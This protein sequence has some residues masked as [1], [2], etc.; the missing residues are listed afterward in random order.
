M[1]RHTRKRNGGP[2]GLT[3]IWK[4][5]RH[6]CCRFGWFPLLVAPLVTA[7]CLLDLYSSFDCEFIR[8]NV[9]FMP[10]ND[11]W[12][13]STASLGLFQFHAMDEAN[14]WDDLTVKGCN[15]YSGG[16]ESQFIEGDRTWEV[17]RIMAY[18][19]AIG[20]IVAT[21]RKR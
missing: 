3:Q 21:V 14:L 2:S 19:S 7:S 17:T 9:G 4:F 20:G 16:F 10:S 6:C 11:A 1:S 12:N 13:Q 8:V 15:R 18:I 5:W